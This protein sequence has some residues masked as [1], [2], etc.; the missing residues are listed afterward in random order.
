MKKEDGDSVV[1]WANAVVEARYSLSVP[2]QRLILWLA[3]QIERED[4]ALQER[5]VGILEMQELSGGHNGR[6]YEQFEEVCTR[7]QGRVLEIR[8]DD[9]RKRRK[10]NWLH[11]SDYN[12]GEGT[13][14]LRFHDD[15]KP[16]LL[17]LKERFSVIPLKT[18]FRLRGGYAVRWYEMLVSKKHVKTFSM[19]V[20][21][22]RL[23]LGIQVDELAA[24]KDLRKRALDI[25]R[26]EL[27]AKAD[28][29]FVYVP[30][31]TG[32]RITGWK[33]TV[34]ENRPRPVQRQLPLPIMEEQRETVEEVSKAKKALAA[35][36]AA[37]KAAARTAGAD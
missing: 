11:R 34:K 26:N 14:T 7:L 31:K 16:A 35:M 32:K 23:W 30:T 4:D 22:L 25:P 29:T 3:A 13:V 28:L 37:V 8:L 24:V 9:K 10:I 20:Q 5:T 36:K 27:S 2:E 12:D 18:V 21:D 33:F 19:S 6:I 17:Q 1:V 15:L